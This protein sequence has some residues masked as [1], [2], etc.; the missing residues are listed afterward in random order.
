[1]GMKNTK[2]KRPTSAELYSVMK[3][4]C[5]VNNPWAF[6]LSWQTENPKLFNKFMDMCAYFKNDERFLSSKVKA[7]E[8]M[9]HEK[10]KKDVLVVSITP[11]EGGRICYWNAD[12]RMFVHDRS[13]LFSAPKEHNQ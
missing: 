9:F 2:I 11:D 4:I 12:T 10:L 7:T 6:C 1:M 8:F 13:E 5:S 3:E